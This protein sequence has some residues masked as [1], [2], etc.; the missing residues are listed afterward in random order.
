[1]ANVLNFNNHCLAYAG[2]RAR[3][4]RCICL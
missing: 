1:M 3:N 2:G 4:K